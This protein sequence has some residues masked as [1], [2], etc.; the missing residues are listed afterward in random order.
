MLTNYVTDDPPSYIAVSPNFTQFPI[1]FVWSSNVK[2]T[3]YVKCDT[4]PSLLWVQLRERDIYY[5]IT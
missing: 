1:A 2:Y 3:N 4:T 5:A